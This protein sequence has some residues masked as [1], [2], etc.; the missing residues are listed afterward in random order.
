MPEWWKR[1]LGEKSQE[2]IGKEVTQEILDQHKAAK[3]YAGKPQ[4]DPL[5]DE[6]PGYYLTFGLA[7][8]G[9]L[10]TKAMAPYVYK[11]IVG[12]L[13]NGQSA[14][15]AFAPGFKKIKSLEELESLRREMEF[16][17]SGKKAVD[18]S[19]NVR[20][21]KR[22]RISKVSE[23]P[24][25][26]VKSF[27]QELA[28]PEQTEF[29]PYYI[30]DGQ[31]PVL[32]GRQQA[33]KAAQVK[34]NQIYLARYLQRMANERGINTTASHRKAMMKAIETN[35][36]ASTPPIEGPGMVPYRTGYRSGKPMMFLDEPLVDWMDA[37]ERQFGPHSTVLQLEKPLRAASNYWEKVREI[38]MKVGTES[39]LYASPVNMEMLNEGLENA[40]S[41][42]K[43][44]GG[45]IFAKSGIHI[46]KKN[47]GKFT[48][49]CGGKV[50]SECIARG[51]ASSNP[52]IRKR[53]TFAANARKWKHQHG[54]KI[55]PYWAYN[56]L[57]G[58]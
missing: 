47:R 24:P 56:M 57:G 30:N 48:S 41:L 38:P 36:A 13:Q 25:R 42:L 32:S 54:G 2:Q 11:G 51:K 6:H 44:Q 17:E 5:V 15:E 53:A 35:P 23:E 4:G 37:T 18:V 46:K 7:Q 1:L 21:G 55:M 29:K 31:A 20:K 22:P 27:T 52:A 9:S 3:A 26:A 34:T 10:L 43:R 8:P 50:T 19:K 12:G 16:A 33:E 28:V 14:F 45:I 49:W 40:A 39:G 58:K